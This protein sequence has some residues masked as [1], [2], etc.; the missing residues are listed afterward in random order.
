MT[1]FR[2]DLS[3]KLL[4]HSSTY[5]FLPHPV[6][7][8]EVHQI[9]REQ[10]TTYQLRRSTDKTLWALKVSNPGYRD[11][12]TVQKT[13]ALQ[14]F[15]H[16]PGLHAANRL[17]LTRTMFPEPLSTYPAL[18][19]AILMPWIQGLT[20]AG[21]MDDASISAA[22]TRQQAQELALTLAYTLW[23]LEA[24]HVT[25]T[26]IAGDNV[27]VLHPRRIELIDI[28]G[29]YSHGMPV[30]PQPSR[31]WR[32]YQHP[33]LDQRGNCRPEGDRYAGAILLTEILTWWKP[34]VRALTDGDSF[35][36]LGDQEPSE[37]MTLRLKAVR[38]TLREISPG[39]LQLFDRAWNSADL[40]ECSDFATWVMALL[41]ARSGY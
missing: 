22:Y 36:Q 24:H 15:Q 35:F 41:Q 4:I 34:L 23:N 40:A 11:P 9:L 12:Q 32:G 38:A 30:P 7:P 5:E 13:E 17:C 14:Q 8:D 3:T 39:L 16:L 1:E 20:W 31:G 28:D 18:E 26:D 27:I 6:L 33:H 19:F 25:H 29:L 21:F 10:A 2:P 37:T